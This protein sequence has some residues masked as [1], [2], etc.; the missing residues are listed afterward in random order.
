VTTLRDFLQPENPMKHLLR[1]EQIAHTLWAHGNEG[2]SQ[3]ITVCVKE[4]RHSLQRATDPACLRCEGHG[5]IRNYINRAGDYEKE[6]CPQ[7]KGSGR[8]P[9]EGA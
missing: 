4:I 8:F 1:L 3:S 7:C 2:L 6:Y 5:V 9:R